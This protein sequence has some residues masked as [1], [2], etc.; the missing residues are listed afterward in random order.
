RDNENQSQERDGDDLSSAEVKRGEWRVGIGK[1]DT[2]SN[3]HRFRLFYGRRCGTQSCHRV[4]VS[5]TAEWRGEHS[6]APGGQ[7][8]QVTRFVTYLKSTPLR[9]V[10][11]PQGIQ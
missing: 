1:V 10:N 5:R 4:H 9:S 3:N 2:R 7:T 8:R 6:T 11:S